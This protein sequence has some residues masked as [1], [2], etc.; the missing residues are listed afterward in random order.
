MKRTPDYV[1]N[2]Y[3]DTVQGAF[4]EADNRKTA[5]EEREEN[6]RCKESSPGLVVPY[7]IRVYIKPHAKDRRP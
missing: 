1:A 5:Q 2:V 6:E 7:R 3:A 4:M